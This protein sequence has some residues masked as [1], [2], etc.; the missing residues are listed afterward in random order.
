MAEPHAE[1]NQPTPPESTAPPPAPANDTPKA[2]AAFLSSALEPT[3]D[4][5]TIISRASQAPIRPEEALAAVLRG[6]RLAHF[7]LL[8]PI[9]VGGMAAVIRATDTQ[10]DRIVA[11]KIL[12]PE[13]ANDPEN[14]RR[15]H[16]EARAAAKLDHENIARVFFCG[17]DQGLHFIAFEFVQGENLRTLLEQRGRIPVPEA[18]GYVLQIATGLTH[19][20]TRG[21]VHR[22]IK[23]SNIII[24][25]NG[26]AK[27]VDMGLARSQEPQSDGGLTQSGV[28]LGTFDYISPEQA[29]EPREADVRSDIYSLGCTFYH[30]V[31]G[32]APVPEGTAAKKLHHH[33]HVHPLDPRQLNPD[34][35]DDVAA[36]LAR[37][38]AKDPSQRYQRPEQ[39]V[40]HLLVLAQKLGTALGQ[41]RALGEGLQTDPNGVLFVDASL[42]GPPRTRPLLLAVAAVVGLVALILVVGPPPW[43]SAPLRPPTMAAT[44]GTDPNPQPDP[45]ATDKGTSTRLADAANQPSHAGNA[46]V[47]TF[48]PE[49]AEALAEFLSRNPDAAHIYLTRDLT[50][51]RRDLLRFRGHELTIEPA[52][53]KW[54]PTLTLTYDP[55]ASEEPWAA[56]TVL[57]GQVRIKG[58]RFVV[59]ARGA[60]EVVMRALA[61]QGGHLTLEECEFFQVEPPAGT[62][63]SSVSGVAVVGPGEGT[64]KPWL[65]VTGC[66]FGS[67]QHAATLERPAFVRFSQ[68]AFGPHTGPLFELQGAASRETQLSVHN[69]S[70]FVSGGAAFRLH[71]SASGRLDVRN[72]LFS[73]VEDDEELGGRAILIEQTGSRTG[74]FQFT[75]GHN[76]YHN[77]DALW[78]RAGRSGQ[79]EKIDDLNAFN[80]RFATGDE[81]SR[82]LTRNP[83]ESLDPLALVRTQQ[84]RDLRAAFRINLTLAEL[85]QG[86]GG[87]PIGVDQC[88]WGKTYDDPLPPLEEKKPTEPVVRK[89]NEKIVDPRSGDEKKG[90]YTTLHRAVE[91]ARRGD[92]ILIRH[93][94]PLL[95][96]PLRLEKASVEVTIRPYP[97]CH[98]I[99]TIGATP[100]PNAALF[101]LYDG[102]LTLEGLEFSLA[103]SHPQV[104]TQSV[105]TVMGD[106]QCT[107]KDCVATLAGKPEGIRRVPLALVRLEDS[108]SVMKMDPQP[109]Q[110]QDPQVEVKNCLVRGA[111]RLMT[112]RVSRPFAL[113]VDDSL[114]AL[115]GSLLAVDGNPRDPG[116]RGADISLKQVT[117]YLTE[118]LICLRAYHEEGKVVKEGLVPTRISSARDCL[119]AAADDTK[120]LIHLEGVDTEDQMKRFFSWGSSEH[121]AYNNFKQMLDQEPDPAS[122]IM[123]A[124]VPYNMARWQDFTDERG[125]PN[126]KVHFPEAPGR[127]G[128]FT[129][130]LATDFKP[131]AASLQ[132]YGTDLEHLPKPA[133]EETSSRPASGE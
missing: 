77:L 127:D 66:C 115:D 69:C 52:D 110:P 51:T 131:P 13:M 18:L 80:S 71:D 34:I 85:R 76:A 19:A 30:M 55:E 130:I 84:L 1:P 117:T 126:E 38:M 62:E 70:A 87:Q 67:G 44:N 109:G 65:T 43:P 32:Q 42:P 2:T 102:K 118:H 125:M 56:L 29:L 58:V 111:G 21:V 104:Q 28:T 26:R 99:L 100:D 37:M 5:P 82:L 121:N 46:E 94:G 106:G 128:S 10:L 45:K 107:F 24:S 108:S 78:A 35:S 129:R 7:E 73:G 59:D 122:M 60:P 120:S 57:A 96:E 47:P 132:G 114:V 61:V 63:K 101:Y 33:Q 92:V 90:T 4:T 86:E 3:D 15:F 36:L 20:A 119:F 6:R 64:G 14:V 25:P 23:P 133:G 93:T 48:R 97:G 113:R 72:S 116:P 105:V 41:N 81:T 53:A 22:D 124:P 49:K 17:E 95:V 91:M 54:H 16:Q 75:S 112:V 103:P 31:T 83:W 74:S 40:Q 88:V 79:P 98:P 12:P 89:P 50:L 11:L 39:L 68:C 8:E 123:T 9:G 27:L